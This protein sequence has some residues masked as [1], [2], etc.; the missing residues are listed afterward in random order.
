MKSLIRWGA[1]LGLIGSALL[2][3]VFSAIM[4][5][6]ALNEEQIVEKLRE[7]LDYQR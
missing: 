2:G 3:S 5:A 6:W 1:T 7:V 4:P